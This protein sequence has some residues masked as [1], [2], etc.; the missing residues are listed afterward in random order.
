MANITKLSETP[1]GYHDWEGARPKLLRRIPFSCQ[2]PQYV[3]LFV[4]FSHK[5]VCV[6][7]ASWINT[8][9]RHGVKILGTLMFEGDGSDI[10]HVLDDEGGEFVIA[11]KLASMARAY[12]FDG[13]LLNFES[14]FPKET[15]NAMWRLTA[16]VRSLKRHLGPSGVVVWYDALTRRNEVEY[17]NALNEE[18][19]ATALA[20]D[21]F[22]TNYRWSDKELRQ[23]LEFA[24]NWSIRPTEIYFG[25]DVWAQNRTL[26][27]PQRIT[28][29]RLGGGG[30]LT[31]VVSCP[32]LPVY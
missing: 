29:P 18:N 19:V 23:T 30:T 17:Q 13:W 15:S 12:G 8:M 1:G 24:Q 20:A 5:L 21:I 31:G 32:R 9:H 16:F 2:Y 7:P 4:Y 6:P 28:Y 10:E 25:I 11:K 14:A 22:F 27:G 3:T 26:W